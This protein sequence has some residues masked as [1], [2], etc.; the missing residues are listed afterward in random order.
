MSVVTSL[1]THRLLPVIQIDD[2]RHTDGL[3]EALLRGGLPVAEVT[4]RT[5]T[6]IEAIGRMVKKYPQLL[7]GAGTVSTAAQVDAVFDAGVQFVVSPG[8]NPAVVARC[9]ELGLTVIPGVCTPTDIEAALG[10]D[11]D[12]LKFFPAEAAG[13]V[14]MLKALSGPYGDIGFVPTGGIGANNILSYLALENVV[15]CGGSWMV[16]P[17]LIQAADF[18]RIRKLV[19]EAVALVALPA[20]PEAEVA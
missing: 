4:L 7:V 15:A 6:A 8:F 13:G 9:L 3:S 18:G 16:S 5:P 12:V 11:L 10:F 19:E 1:K 17:R 14:A 20:Q 2:A